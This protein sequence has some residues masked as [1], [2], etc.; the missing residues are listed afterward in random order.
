MNFLKNSEFFLKKVEHLSESVWNKLWA[1]ILH[2]HTEK[3][4]NTTRGCRLWDVNNSGCKNLSPTEVK[5]TFIHQNLSIFIPKSLWYFCQTKNSPQNQR[6]YSSV[7]ELFH[8][9]VMFISFSLCCNHFTSL[10]YEIFYARKVDLFDKIKEVVFFPT[11]SVCVKVLCN[12][13]FKAWFS[14][15]VDIYG[16]FFLKKK[17][18]HKFAICGKFTRALLAHQLFSCERLFLVPFHC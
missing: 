2:A 17:L 1:K 3:V 10:A 6:K 9:K 7:L 5:R 14:E 13:R 18:I 8:I 16:S 4:R 15:V 12:K 11:F